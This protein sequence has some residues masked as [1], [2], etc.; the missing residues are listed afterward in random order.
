[1]QQTIAQ[2]VAALDLI[3]D[4]TNANI[5]PSERLALIERLARKA[6]KDSTN[7]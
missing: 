7:A 1:M 6:I 3:A 4:T 5:P 2:L